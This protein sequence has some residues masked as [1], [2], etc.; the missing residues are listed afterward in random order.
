M[1]FKLPALA[2]AFVLSSFA[3][4]QPPDANR[5]LEGARM[6]ATLVELDE[7]LSGT[8]T[9]DRRKVPVALFLKGENIQFQFNEGGPWRVFHMQLANDFR[10]S[11]IVN[12][13]TIAFPPGRLVEPIAGTDLTYE[14]LAFRFFYWPN[15][16]LET[17]EN[18][19]G[20]P[21]YRLRLTKP[22]GVAGNYK[23]VYLWV[24]T[25]FGAFMRIRGHN[26]AGGLVKEF[27]VQDVMQVT[28]NVWSL[29][30]MQVATHD[31]ASGRR[32]SITDVT[33]APPKKAAPRVAR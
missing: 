2:A 12:G 9:K 29:R 23:T 15:P 21:C 1:N 30:K 3:N 19:N 11:E 26:N 6:A 28:K 10:L 14:D 31:P 5:I 24:H 20:Q 13:K 4:A 33:F 16:V 25:K 32:I 17:Q 27:Q 8:I 22:A 18:V 7:G